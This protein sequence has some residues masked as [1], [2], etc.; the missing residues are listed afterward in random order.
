MA[1]G[2]GRA[3]DAAFDR[4]IASSPLELL[5][6]KASASFPE[7][8]A[9]GP[10]VV[11]QHALGLKVPRNGHEL[12]VRD[13]LGVARKG[14]GGRERRRISGRSGRRTRARREKM[15]AKAH[16]I[17]ARGRD[18]GTKPSKAPRAVPR[19]AR[20][21]A[22]EEG[23]PAG[24]PAAHHPRRPHHRR[25]P[26]RRKA[27][28]GAPS[29]SP[30]RARVAD[31]DRASTPPLNF[32]FLFVGAFPIFEMW[33][34]VTLT[35]GSWKDHD[36][37]TSAGRGKR[38]APRER[39]QQPRRGPGQAAAERKE[40]WCA[41]KTTDDDDED[42]ESGRENAAPRRGLRGRH[43]DRLVPRGCP[44][45]RLD[46]DGS[47]GGL[48]PPVPVEGGMPDERRGFAGGRDLLA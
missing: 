22:R 44:S 12:F 25:T 14:D 27:S 15:L 26:R 32:F 39:A 42:D 16:L 4:S 11:H 29:L 6:L 20:E 33:E 5:H 43:D 24:K 19:R 40:S 21:V 38:G 28:S 18:R 30:T 48:G 13:R 41:E 1:K 2:K 3:R 36:R 31:T 47:R 37:E 35:V 46:D 45:P 9:C 7:D 34:S 8:R 17:V 23:A 10:H